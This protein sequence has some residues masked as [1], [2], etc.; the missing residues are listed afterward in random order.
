MTESERQRSKAL[1]SRRTFL[2]VGTAAVAATTVGSAATGLGRA[3]TRKTYSIRDGSEDESDVVVVDSGSPGATAVVVGGVHGNEPAGHE[4]ARAM[5]GW[6]IDEGKLVLVPRANPTALEAGTYSNENGNLNRKF[7]PGEE[8]TTPLARAIWGVVTRHDADVVM[9]LHSS[10]GIYGADVGPDG[11]GQ[12]IYPTTAPGARRNAA[13]AAEYVNENHLDDSWPDHYR[14]QRG[15][16]IDGDRPL[17]IHKVDADLGEPGFIVET[18]KYGTSLDTRVDWTLSIVEYLLGRYSIDRVSA[19][20][21]GD[22]SDGGAD[23]RSPDDGSSEE[24]SSGDTSDGERSSGD[25]SADGTQWSVD[26]TTDEQ[27]ITEGSFD[28]AVSEPEFDGTPGDETE[29]VERPSETSDD[30]GWRRLVGVYLG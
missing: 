9:S 14:F 8:P 3:A 4:A 2:R 27:T 20:S 16:R 15:N 1:T 23:P 12:A 10:K 7:P 24:Q 18:T 13:A 21:S 22:P 19:P 5:R 17:L 26:V 30:D 11:V 29:I 25:D 6:S 28:G